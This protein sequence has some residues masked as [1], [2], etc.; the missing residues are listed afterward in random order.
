[1]TRRNLISFLGATPVM[2]AMAAPVDKRPIIICFDPSRVSTDSIDSPI[3]TGWLT[4]HKLDAIIVPVLSPE[5]PFK[6]IDLS[7]LKP[8]EM[9]EVR[10]MLAKIGDR[11]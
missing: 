8:A 3:L 2:P 4:D 7:N 1:M 11:K 10:A 6:I 9:E 5:A